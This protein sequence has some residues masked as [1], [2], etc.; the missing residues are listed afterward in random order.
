MS[1]FRIQIYLKVKYFL[2]SF[3]IS[4]K[5]LNKKNSL[6]INKVTKKKYTLFLGQLR[7]GFYLVLKYLKKNNPNKDEIIMSSYNLAEMVNICESLGLKVIF[8]KLNENIFLSSK[9]VKKHI[10]KKTLAVVVTNIFNSPKDLNNIKKICKNTKTKLIE[11]NAIY[12]GNFYNKLGKRVYAGSFGDYSLNSFNIMKIISAMFGGSVS[13]DDKNFFHYANK[14]LERLKSFPI[15]KYFKQCLIFIILKLLTIKIL[16]RFFF[17]QILKRAHITNNKFFLSIVY[18]SMKFQKIKFTNKNLTKINPLSTRM[19]WLQLIDQY[20]LSKYHQT[21]KENNAHYYKIF[22][23]T[24]IN[25]LKFIEIED[26]NFQ[27]FNDFP[28]ITNQKKALV[29]YLLKKGIET[30]VIQYVDC[31]KIFSKRRKKT[32]QSYEEK[33]LCLPNHNKVSKKY[34]EYIVN[35]I[36]NFYVQ[37]RKNFKQK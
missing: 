21:K 15:V 23:R 17:F 10:N 30:K 20:N 31:E 37:E 26:F 4:K 3:F 28:I 8:P 19:V 13:S 5:T 12:Y 14:E 16:Y 35:N 1:I 34:I 25:E 24:K 11:D 36:K 6:I 9:D 7:V 32:A 27:N 2:A 29:K 22:K 33:V 18:P